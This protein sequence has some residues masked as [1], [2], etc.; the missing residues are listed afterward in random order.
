MYADVKSTVDLGNEGIN[1]ILKLRY[2]KFTEL[3][4]LKAIIPCVLP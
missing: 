1:H 4:F 3:V 2:V